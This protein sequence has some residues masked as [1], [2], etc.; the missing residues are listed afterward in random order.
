MKKYGADHEMAAE[1]EDVKVYDIMTGANEHGN[2]MQ[3]Q[4]QGKDSEIHEGVR[5][6]HGRLTFTTANALNYQY[7]NFGFWFSSE[8]EPSKYDGVWFSVVRDASDQG[9][10]FTVTD[11]GINGGPPTI[12]MVFLL[13][14]DCLLYTSDAA[15]E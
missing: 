4:I 5:E 7:I 2:T 6:L 3:L 11:F 15:D 13:D 8:E 1:A 10:D 9:T 12:D 14:E